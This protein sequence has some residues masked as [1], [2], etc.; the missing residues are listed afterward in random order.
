MTKKVIRTYYL[1]KLIEFNPIKGAE[2]P[3]HP[4]QAFSDIASLET[5]F[6]LVK[7]PKLLNIISYKQKDKKNSKRWALYLKNW[8]SYSYFCES[9]QEGI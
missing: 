8:P 4:L 3:P 9:S 5:F 2:R 7:E 6:N 1:A